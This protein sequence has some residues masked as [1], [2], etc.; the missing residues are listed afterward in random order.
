M[1]VEITNAQVVSLTNFS[2]LDINYKLL[3]TSSVED[4]RNFLPSI[5]FSKDTAESIMY[6][7]AASAVGV[8]EYNNVIKQ[9]LWTSGTGWGKTGWNSNNGRLQRMLLKTLL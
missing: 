5:N 7:G 9:S 6:A 1:S 4:E 8:G 2:N 3:T